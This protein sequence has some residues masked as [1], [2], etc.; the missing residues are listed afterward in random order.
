MTALG[1]F[2]AISGKFVSMWVS[3]L[4]GILYRNE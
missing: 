1:S 4:V 3:V 2:D